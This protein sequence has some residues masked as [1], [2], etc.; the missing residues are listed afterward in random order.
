M[1]NNVNCMTTTTLDV[2]SSDAIIRVR[3]FARF[4]KT[5][6]PS[7]YVIE[8][9]DD[10]LTEAQLDDLIDLLTTARTMYQQSEVSLP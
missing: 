4:D 5:P 3:H 1:T 10:L 7:P 6:E 2:D 9:N 8:I